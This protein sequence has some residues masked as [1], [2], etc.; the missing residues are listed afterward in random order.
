MFS[1]S[2]AV[3]A[4]VVVSAAAGVRVDIFRLLRFF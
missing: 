1:S 2:V 3:E 4:A